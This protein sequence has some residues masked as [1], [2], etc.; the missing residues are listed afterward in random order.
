VILSLRK[1][2][3]AGRILSA[4]RNEIKTIAYDPVIHHFEESKKIIESSQLYSAL[5]HMPKGGVLHLHLCSTVSADFL[6]DV[7]LSLR[8]MK[9]K[10]AEFLALSEMR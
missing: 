7:I 9:K 1:M 10:Q 4:L 5:D 2:K 3:K 6:I 8:K